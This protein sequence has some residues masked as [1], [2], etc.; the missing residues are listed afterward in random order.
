MS[1]ALTFDSLIE[2][3]VK[4]AGCSNLGDERFLEPFGHFLISLENTGELHPFGRFYAK[5]VI[6][7]LLANRLNLVDLWQH[8]P[9]IMDERI[10]RP[11]I[12]I[13]LPRT[14][15]SF[16]FSILSQDPAHR[17]LSNW[18]ATVSQVA[19]EGTYSYEFDPRRKQGKFLMTLQ[20]HLAPH[21]QEIHEFHLDGPEECTPL[22]MQGFAT[23]ALSM[24]FNVP[25][26]SK[27]LNSASHVSTYCHHKNILKTL[28]WKYPA[29]RWVLKSPDHIQAV[30]VILDVYPDACIVN[31]QRDPIKCVPSW[32]SLNAV[33]RGIH[34]RSIDVDELG[35]QA[36]DRLAMDFKQFQ[37]QRKRCDPKRFID[38]DYDELMRDP[39]ETVRRIY[40]RFNFC[41]SPEFE[42]RGQVYVAKEREIKRSHE[43]NL[44]KFGLTPQIIRRRFQSCSGAEGL[45]VRVD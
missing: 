8:R 9:E 31:L 13:G 33:F 2:K 10:H 6:V 25:S 41:L 43:Y 19:P 34:S 23:Q 28:Q 12:I 39:L 40:R 29:E 18:E 16:L 30:G 20:N 27:W 14:G 11:L 44:E 17:Y 22:L 35:L 32:A 5:N 36:L 7:G 45:S 3:A 37:I 4:I 21:L 38:I 26:Y 42:E 1:P 24:I 15:S